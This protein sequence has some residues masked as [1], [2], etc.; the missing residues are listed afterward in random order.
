MRMPTGS[1]VLP[2]YGRIP[3]W[4]PDEFPTGPAPVVQSGHPVTMSVIPLTG[5]R[6]IW[7]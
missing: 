4:I 1:V 2:H 5:S 6:G 7:R 3:E